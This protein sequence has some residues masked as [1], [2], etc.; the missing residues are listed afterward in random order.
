MP[1]PSP[2]RPVAYD[3]KS[4]KKSTRL[5]YLLLALA[6]LIMVVFGVLHLFGQNFGVQV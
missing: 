5:M 3:A 1:N 6:V 4:S 2:Q